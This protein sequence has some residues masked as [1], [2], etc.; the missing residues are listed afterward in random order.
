M[1]VEDP[2]FIKDLPWQKHDGQPFLIEHLA[3]TLHVFKIEVA[4][5]F[6]KNDISSVL[7]TDEMIKAGRFLHQEDKES[8]MISSFIKRHIIAKFLQ[9]PVDQIVFSS[10]KNGKPSVENLQFNLSNTKKY[11]LIAVS[12]KSIGIDIEYANPYF[13]Y[14]DLVQHSFNEN[15][16]L[17]I[18]NGQNKIL[19]FYTLWTRKEALLKA[20]GEGLVEDMAQVPSIG[21]LHI[22]QADTFKIESLV[23]EDHH[24]ISFAYD[25]GIRFIKLWEYTDAGIL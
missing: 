5:Y 8:Y 20:T 23:T 19:N 13:N 7:S 10:V 3:D 6:K 1:P 21:D 15:E 11:V 16:Q 17:F 12:D 9:L 24:V 22:R 14:S 4:T 2:S 25:P 18:L